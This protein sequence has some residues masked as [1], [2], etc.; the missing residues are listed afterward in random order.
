MTLKEMH[1]WGVN[2]IGF[3]H[4]CEKCNNFI[5]DNVQLKDGSEA[6]SE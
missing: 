6:I 5:W 1:P 4:R 2:S 3:F